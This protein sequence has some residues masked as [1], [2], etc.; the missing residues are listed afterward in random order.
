MITNI[1]RM[2]Y[3]NKNRIAPGTKAQVADSTF[4]NQKI[5]LE[6]LRLDKSVNVFFVCK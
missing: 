4:S 6:T 2:Q 3:Q 1:D 5:N